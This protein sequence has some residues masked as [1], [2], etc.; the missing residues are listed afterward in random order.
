[1]LLPEF[2]WSSA[3]RH[4][5]ILL[6]TLAAVFASLLFFFFLRTIRNISYHLWTLP[7]KHCS[8]TAT[9]YT[10]VSTQDAQLI[11]L[12]PN[13]HAESISYIVKHLQCIFMNYEIALFTS[14]WLLLLAH[15]CLLQCTAATIAVLCGPQKC[16][17]PSLCLWQACVLVHM[18]I[19][20]NKLWSIYIYKH[21]LIHYWFK[22]PWYL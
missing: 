20:Q 7:I 22:P 16:I 1:M 9:L 21:A 5:P 14:V 10:F 13:K 2:Q 15:C 19:E 3:S 18:F 6:T 11:L 17:T 8:L 12:R 4:F